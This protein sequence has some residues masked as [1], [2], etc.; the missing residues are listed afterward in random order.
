M[1]AMLGRGKS[2]QQVKVANQWC[3]SQRQLIN[4]SSEAEFQTS[5]EYGISKAEDENVRPHIVA[6]RACLIAHMTN[7]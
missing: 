7:P 5:W 3:V 2:V 6:D 4:M 1:C